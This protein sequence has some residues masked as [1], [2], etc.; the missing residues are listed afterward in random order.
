MN[1]KQFFWA[2][3]LICSGAFNAQAQSV[4]LAKDGSSYYQNVGGEIV[5]ITLPK[6]ERKTVIRRE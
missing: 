5:N 6:N 3:C 1:A 4:N 2:V